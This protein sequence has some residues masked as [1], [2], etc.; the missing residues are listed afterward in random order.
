MNI[1]E[2][3]NDMQRLAVE[4]TEG[5]VLVLA[6]AGSGKTKALVT[7]AAYLLQEV[8]IRP[9]ELLAFTFTN[10]AAQEM[11][12]RM[13]KLTGY[14]V[15]NM[16]VGTFHG[17]CLRILRREAQYLP[18]D[19]QFIIYDD[20]DQQTLLKRI[21]KEMGLKD[22][23]Y[24]P[25]A[26]SSQISK[27]KN[28]LVTPEEYLKEIG[29]EWE[30]TVG[31]VYLEYQRRLVSANAMD[32]DDLIMYTLQLFESHKDV[33]A[34]YQQ[35]FRYIMVDE[36]QDTN[37]S[38]YY[39]IRLLAEGSRNICAVGDPD[40]SIYGW[41]GA[42]IGN[43]LN[44]E[45]DY[46][47]CKLIKLEQNY[48][49][50]KNILEASNKVI[51][52][53]TQRKPKALWTD[54]PEG[55]LIEYQ[56]LPDDRSEGMFVVE[57]IA[58]MREQGFDYKDF[59][60]VYRT[61][62]QA[63]VLEDAL[64]KYGYPYH[65]Y[66]GMKFYER[67][68]IK[69]TLAYLRLLI[70]P[71]DNLSLARIIN[72]PKRSIGA[73]SYQKLEEGAAALNIPVYRALSR[74]EVLETLSPTAQKSVKNF[75]AMIER[76]TKMSKEVEIPEL[77]EALWTETGYYT[78]LEQ[79]DPTSAETRMDNLREFAASAVEFVD[80]M[81]EA[82][83]QGEVDEFDDAEDNAPTLENFLARIA[84]VTD[85]DS[86]NSEDGSITL[87]TMHAAKG[88]EFPVVFMVGMEEKIFPHSRSLL[89]ESEME[90]ERRLCY[91]AMTRAKKRLIMT[92]A[93]RRNLF[94]QYVT[95]PPSRFVSEIPSELMNMHTLSYR[96]PEVQQD[97]APK[98]TSIFVSRPKRVFQPQPDAAKQLI[99]IG[100]K[101]QHTKFGLGVV[102][103]VEGKGEEAALSIAFPGQGIKVLI[104]KYA[105]LKVVK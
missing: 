102:V 37:Y 13:E 70:N 89:D 100:D 17:I 99:N 24:H 45:K 88:L 12:E 55:E 101:V 51:A 36:Y 25:R 7:R 21:L 1:L 48:R 66:G 77:L 94:G 40:Q 62:P 34:K 72:E 57:T 5:P 11:C 81:R 6:G 95:L 74:P 87:L 33:L 92:R 68:E 98:S 59:A 75:V 26:V 30:N 35:R 28:Q 16:W 105:P 2:E 90:E 82:Q 22:K 103:K 27:C 10:K 38:Q 49:S 47:D 50:T 29:T 84:L 39:L 71:D 73:G 43:I 60:V 20:G 44:F 15:R 80:T 46:K 63:R 67:K 76:L 52:N 97:P 18:F 53:N 8:G 3:L 83:E 86:Y 85:T 54:A 23:E 14:S 42:D 19:S 31:K 91:V 32:F 64:L 104:Q 65:V 4:T 9:G 58:M 69:D 41:R 79:Q 96:R 78:A 61:H 56:E 93:M